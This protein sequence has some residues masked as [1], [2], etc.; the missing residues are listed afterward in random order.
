[1]LWIKQKKFLKFYGKLKKKFRNSFFSSNI[2]KKSEGD[3]ADFN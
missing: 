3:L 1:M 2:L